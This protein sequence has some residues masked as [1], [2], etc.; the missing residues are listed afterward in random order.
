MDPKRSHI[1]LL[2]VKGIG[3][4]VFSGEPNGPFVQHGLLD[5]T[6]E[7]PASFLSMRKRFE[8]VFSTRLAPW[9]IQ[10]RDDGHSQ[11]VSAAYAVRLDVPDEEERTGIRFVHT[12]RT[13]PEGTVYPC[14]AAML[15]LLS[16]RGI[17]GITREVALLARRGG[18]V[19]RFLS[20]V[21]A[22]LD[23]LIDAVPSREHQRGP[24][25]PRL[26]LPSGTATQPGDPMIRHDCAG[27]AAVA[28]L[29]YGMLK[30][31]SRAPWEVFD[32][33]VRHREV[34]T[35]SGTSTENNVVRASEIL[36]KC[37]HI[38]DLL[39]STAQQ[40]RHTQRTTP[41]PLELVGQ[42]GLPTELSPV[43]VP[44]D[45][46]DAPGD[47]AANSFGAPPSAPVAG[48]S[49]SG[50]DPS[51]WEA[52]PRTRIPRKGVRLDREQI[53]AAHPLET[54]TSGRQP[55]READKNGDEMRRY[56]RMLADELREAVRL[57]MSSF[58]DSLNRVSVGSDG[59]H[60]HRVDVWT[61]LCFVLLVPACCTILVLLWQLLDS[62]YGAKVART[63]VS[64]LI[65]VTLVGGAVVWFLGPRRLTRTEDRP[66]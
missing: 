41:P 14:V 6:P 44:P 43:P 54:G 16:N 62:Q 37:V 32:C 64:A 50:S 1:F 5:E 29:Y 17:T 31:G 33:V 20:Q 9:S 10:F 47:P 36:E 38:Q 55:L 8:E 66:D 35:C 58:R 7:V 19:Q 18:D 21:A 40:A 13:T 65:V 45:A 28:W 11:G 15:R 39:Q 30:E 26:P 22:E 61:R 48:V 25:A 24:R 12:V 2:N 60:Q 49:T 42:E 51:S 59:A 23:R 3:Y 56:V 27:G 63:V 57:E 34:C 46:T 4:A 53:S 52:A